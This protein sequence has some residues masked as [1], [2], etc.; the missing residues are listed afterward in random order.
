MIQI[1]FIIDFEILIA[2]AMY[3][4]FGDLQIL[5]VKRICTFNGDL[6]SLLLT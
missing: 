2:L 4:F 1:L 3:Y 6:K 5:S